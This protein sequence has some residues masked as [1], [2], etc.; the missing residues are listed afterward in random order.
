MGFGHS[1]ADH[2]IALDQAESK[3]ARLKVVLW[4]QGNIQS[5]FDSFNVFGVCGVRSDAVLLHQRYQVSF[6]EKS[7]CLGSTFFKLICFNIKSRTL[8]FKALTAYLLES[9]WV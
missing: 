2:F 3:I 6:G 5:L 8:L 1:I 9:S 7:R 4:I